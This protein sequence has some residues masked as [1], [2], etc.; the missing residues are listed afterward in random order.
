MTISLFMWCDS[1]FVDCK[2]KRGKKQQQEREN[3]CEE[4]GDSK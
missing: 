1:K 3:E 4:R 2:Q